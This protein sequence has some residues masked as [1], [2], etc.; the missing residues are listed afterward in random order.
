MAVD[1]FSVISSKFAVHDFIEITVAKLNY[2]NRARI[3]ITKKQ[4]DYF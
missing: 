2:D 4:S 3:V 1:G